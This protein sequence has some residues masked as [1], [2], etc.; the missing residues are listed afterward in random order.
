MSF[1]IKSLHQLVCLFLNLSLCRFVCFSVCYLSVCLSIRLS[2]HL[3]IFYTCLSVYLLRLSIGFC[4][5]LFLS[6]PFNLLFC[7][8]RCFPIR[9]S[10]HLHVC[11][12]ICLM[13]VFPSVSPSFHLSPC[14]S[15]CLEKF[16]YRILDWL[17]TLS[18]AVVY[19]VIDFCS[20]CWMKKKI[21][22]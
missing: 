13:Y 18:K 10:F 15:A 6:L 8:F 1:Y 14:V 17:G 19:I 3:I 21:H 20:C 22:E 2:Y 7:L 12:L 16:L 5:C 11:L 4:V 9:L